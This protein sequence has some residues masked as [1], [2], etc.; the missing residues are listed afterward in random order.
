MAITLIYLLLT[1]YLLA[2]LHELGHFLTAKLLGFQIPLV[3]I[4]LPFTPYLTFLKTTETEFRMHLIPFGIYAEVPELDIPLDDSEGNASL[5]R[6]YRHFPLLKKVVVVASGAVTSLLLGLFI[7]NG[8]LVF[9]GTPQ[10]KVSVHGLSE[11]N[12][13]AKDAGILPD[14]AIVSID[15]MEPKSVN[16]VIQYFKSHPQREIAVRLNRNGS[17]VFCSLAPNQ[18]GRVGLQIT[19]EPDP[20]KPVKRFSILEASQQTIGYIA[21]MTDGVLK[22]IVDR[23]A[24]VS[25]DSP[26]LSTGNGLFGVA[27]FMTDENIDNDARKIC[28]FTSMLCFDFAILHCLPLPGFDGSH[29]LSIVLNHFTKRRWE[30]SR[31]MKWMRIAS[32]ALMFGVG[33]Y[34]LCL[35]R[36]KSLKDK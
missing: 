30:S 29:M 36:G 32:L 14:D 19:Q 8:S 5:S 28:L 31:A 12:S 11:S 35:L 6:P 33:N 13:I 25:T 22:M 20:T 26:S 1:M 2:I 16:D 4:G 3:G 9:L 18:E 17:E 15:S 23:F 34:F 10:M 7:L 27:A 21:S 24:P